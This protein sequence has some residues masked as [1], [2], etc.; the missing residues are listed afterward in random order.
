MNAQEKFLDSYFCF[1][2]RYTS[3]KLWQ[4][5][6]KPFSENNYLH[7]TTSPA[8]RNSFSSVFALFASDGLHNPVCSAC[9]LL[10]LSVQLC[11]FS[12]GHGD[13]VLCETPGI[14]FRS[15]GLFSPPICMVRGIFA[16]AKC[17]WIRANC[18]AQ[19]FDVP[20]KRKDFLSKIRDDFDKI[21]RVFPAFL[22]VP[23]IKQPRQRAVK[24]TSDINREQ[25]FMRQVGGCR[26]IF[27][28]FK[29]SR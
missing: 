23:A 7:S 3:K 26:R 15:H 21:R 24:S 2:S 12:V 14:D 9:T 20:G 13:A 27:G 28:V 16:S 25:G 1:P 17:D 11:A 10:P 18:G 8:D 19:L 29:C 5:S 4:K 6:S 22:S